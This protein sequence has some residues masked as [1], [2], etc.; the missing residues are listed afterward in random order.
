ME[1]E[2]WR[3]VEVW[4]VG[5][6]EHSEELKVRKWALRL[7]SPRELGIHKTRPSARTQ[8]ERGYGWRAGEEGQGREQ[9]R[10]R[11][12]SRG[13]GALEGNRGTFCSSLKIFCI[14]PQAILSPS[15]SGETRFW[16]LGFSQLDGT[17][18]VWV[19]FPCQGR[20]GR[21]WSGKMSSL[22]WLLLSICM[23]LSGLWE[24]W[25]CLPSTRVLQ[26][27]EGCSLVLNRWACSTC[28]PFLDAVVGSS[29][30]EPLLGPW[31]TSLSPLGECCCAQ[32]LL[33]RGEGWGKEEG[34]FLVGHNRCIRVAKGSYVG[35]GLKLCS[36]KEIRESFRWLLRAGLPLLTTTVTSR[37]TEGTSL[38]LKSPRLPGLWTPSSS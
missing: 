11:L 38:W 36:Q 14:T 8:T 6:G 26:G 9:G 35:D 1:V 34:D 18:T 31:L 32:V 4:M 29:G 30:H 27:P 33:G 12:R 16:T 17:D 21:L 7:L 10:W 5:V 20:W 19:D 24:Q 3:K 23:S 2:V 22:V 37:S 13:Q 15:L 28:C 25:P